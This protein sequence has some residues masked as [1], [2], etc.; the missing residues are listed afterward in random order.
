MK[1][2]LSFITASAIALIALGVFA[3]TFQAAAI[4]YSS[5]EDVTAAS[6]PV[7]PG[8]PNPRTAPESATDRGYVDP[9][10][11]I[12][13]SYPSRLFIPAL[14]IDAN[15]QDV[16]ITARGSIGSPNNFTDVGWYDLGVTPGNPGT[17]LIDGHVDNGLALAGVFKHLS[18]ISDGD[19]VY[20]TTHGGTKL[21]FLVTSVSIYDYQSVPLAQMMA[22]SSGSQLILITCDGA[23]VGDQ[24][25]YDKRLV[26]TAELQ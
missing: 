10:P 20:I 25:T 24:K 19:H 12:P 5:P 23:W 26:V 22:S 4:T 17:A 6:S 11:V 21:D 8:I 2:F 1:R 14:K 18:D 9:A 7:P 16:G 3:H 13:A 15:V